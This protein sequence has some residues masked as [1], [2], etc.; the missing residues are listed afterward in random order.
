MTSND[1]AAA[2]GLVILSRRQ[3]LGLTGMGAAALVAA[4]CRPGTRPPTTT[5]T[6]GPGGGSC[7]LTPKQTEGP[8]YLDNDLVRSDITDGR[9]GTPLSLRLLVENGSCA[10]LP[11]AIVDVW[12]CD[13]SGAYSGF[14]A[15]A[16]SRSFLRGTQIADA[17]GRVTF[18]T[19]Y[20]GWY[21]GRATHIHVKV[22]NGGREIHTGQLYFD[23]ALNDAVYRTAPY[24]SHTGTRTRNTSDFIYLGGGA[25]S[26]VAVAGSGAG[27][28]GDKTL[29]VA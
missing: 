8:Y 25:Q 22:H 29:V 15:G 5:T 20:P 12:H 21:A 7:V 16:S 28:T 4:G 23:E 9:P 27:Y 24:A 19:V 2:R 10:P 13:A 14:G 26:M 17:A 6:T 3:L 11:G 18:E 1:D